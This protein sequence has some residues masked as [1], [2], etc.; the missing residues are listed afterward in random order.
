MTHLQSL[1]ISNIVIGS[2]VFGWTL[3]QAASFKVLDAL[4]EK[5]LR[6][7]DTA[8]IYSRWVPGNRG[9]ESERIIG[10]WSQE[11]NNRDQLVIITKVGMEVEDGQGLARDYILKA[12][13]NSLQRLQTEYI[14]VYLS[15]CEDKSTPIADTLEAYQELLDA[16]KVR[17]IGGS[18]YSFTGL[19]T[20]AEVAQSQGLTPYQVYQPEYNLYARAEFE[21]QYQAFCQQHNIDVIPYFALASGFLTGKYRDKNDAGQSQRGEGVVNK[22]LNS[23]G[24][25]IL[26]AMDTVSE[27]TGA[28]LA[29][30]ALAWLMKQPAITAPI[31]SV[32]KPAHIDAL[33]AALKL[34]LSPAQLSELDAA[35]TTEN[36]PS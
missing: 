15:H 16:K 24:E 13:E 29:A 30:I 27:E 19:Q 5:G 7:F 6:T 31:A 8:N 32:T 14:D 12:C 36:K 23:R 4:F 2:N 11:R 20:M 28:P 17:V 9:G 1:A 34:D 21:H 35:S 26:A 18:N 22:Y 10:Q 33:E 25:R 3:D